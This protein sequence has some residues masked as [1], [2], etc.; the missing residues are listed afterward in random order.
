MNDTAQRATL[1]LEHVDIDPDAEGEDALLSG[2]SWSVVAYLI[3]DSG[4]RERTTLCRHQTRDE[5]ARAMERY[6]AGLTARVTRLLWLLPLGVGLVA[7]W[8]QHAHYGM[9]PPRVDH[10]GRSDFFLL[11]SKPINWWELL[12]HTI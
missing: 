7:A 2:D 11:I 1:V 5:A 4:R 10:R 12:R 8:V 9:Q 6:W 3:M